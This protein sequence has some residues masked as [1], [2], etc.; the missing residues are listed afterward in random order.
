MTEA[1]SLLRFGPEGWGDELARGLLTTIE[2]CGLALPTGLVLGLVFGL[3]QRANNVL[4]REA[5]SLLT[6]LVRGVPELLTL[7]LVYFG[8]QWALNALFDA[9][10]AALVPLSGFAAGAVTLAIIF[11]AYSSDVF[12]G[13]LGVMARSSLDAAK[14]LGLG[15]WPTA[16]FILLPEL[17]RLSLPGLSNLWIG[18]VKQTALVSIIGS[19]ELLRASY[20]AASSSGQKILFYSVVCLCYLAITLVSEALLAGLARR[21]GRGRT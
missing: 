13:A 12:A 19:S 15:R 21:L 5:S 11:C 17:A 18:M 4:L 10:G 9:I 2:L 6:S 3:A 14:A 16:A 1:L 8:G 20:V 7:L